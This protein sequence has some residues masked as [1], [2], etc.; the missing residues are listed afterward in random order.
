MKSLRFLL[1]LTLATTVSLAEVATQISVDGV[2]LPATASGI[3]WVQVTN[4]GGRGNPD[5]GIGVSYRGEQIKIDLY[6]Y[7]S[8]NADWTGLPIK[9]RI[10]KENQSIA[11][12]FAQLTER[13]DYSNVNIKP[14][15]V[16]RRGNREFTHTEIT[17]T[18]KHAGDLNSHYYLSELN[19]RILK[20]RISCK[21][22]ST[23]ADAEAAF[24]EIATALAAK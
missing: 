20:I 13:G 3:P 15:R 9:E 12:I 17:F 11:T 23:P 16:T 7:D 5:Q 2:T 4:Y 10:E 8:L 14:V 1:L 21:A 24:K 18:D 6:V 19:G 22:D